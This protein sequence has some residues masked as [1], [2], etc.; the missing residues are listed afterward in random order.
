MIDDPE[1]PPVGVLRLDD[2][3]ARWRVWAPNAEAVAL[4]LGQGESAQ[5]LPMAAE[6]R[7]YFAVDAPRPK[8]GDRY[9]YALD[10]DDPRPDP[11]SRWQPGGVGEPS[12]AWWP[13]EP[14]FDW[15]EGSWKGLLREDLVVYE[16]HV[17][18]F[19]TEGAF[20]SVIPR[21]GE[22]RELGIT[23]VELMPVAQFPGNFGWGYDGVF[24]FAVQ[25]T[26]G[27]PDGLRRLVAACHRAG[28]AVILDVIYNHFGPDGNVFPAFAKAYFNDRYRTDWGPAVNYDGYGCD[29]MR[30]LVIENVRHWVGSFRVDGLRLDAADQ[31]YDRSPRPILAEVVQVA[32]D[33][34]A[35]LGRPCHVFA[36]TDMNDARR[37]LGPESAGGC[38]LDGYWNDDFHHA[39]H[40]ALTGDACGYFGDFQDGIG[41][42]A[43][44]FEQI[45][46]NNG[47][48]SG[49]RSRRHGAPAEEFPGDRFLAFVQN[50]DQ[51]ANGCHGRRIAKLLPPAGARLAAGLL[52]LAP[53]IPM[54]FQGEEY[55]ETNDFHYF[56]DYASPELIQGVRE[57][58]ARE[59]AHF[60]RTEVPPDPV[61]PSTR[62]AAVLS[63]RWA[64]DPARSGLRRLYRDLLAL[65]HTAPAL[66]DFRPART[67]RHGDHLEVARGE[68]DATL[69]LLYNFADAPRPL[70][71]DL[72]DRAPS[73]RSEVADYGSDAPSPPPGH[74]HGREFA[75]FG[76]LQ[77]V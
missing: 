1:L 57:G 53:R 4:V 72:A 19:T 56:A 23:A 33:D 63:W 68:G 55:G 76:L 61:A 11:A 34:A 65:R 41:S 22:L 71:H 36:E 2:M 29:P 31:I 50:H 58:R 26:Y 12:A 49:F 60:H 70:P 18:T 54:L 62:D 21:L 77:P 75:L 64:G 48:Y 13:D 43:K 3:T 37:F 5:R 74:L 24:P 20:D 10:A 17:N 52:L 69:R 47:N 66:R 6:P 45:F 51:I 38:N 42:L 15:D 40:V 25:N 28:L 44:V 27:G 73:F 59:F 8:P 32:H 9:A 35:R 67:A 14:G 7:G 30:A 39:A 46:A 16:L